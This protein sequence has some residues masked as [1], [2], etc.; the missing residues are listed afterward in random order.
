MRVMRGVS[1][2]LTFVVSTTSSPAVAAP[3]GVAFRPFRPMVLDPASVATASVAVFY[4]DEDAT[5]ENDGSEY[6]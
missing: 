5:K 1:V 4:V 2:Y 6:N 3:L